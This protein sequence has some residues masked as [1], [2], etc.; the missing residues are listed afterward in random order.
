[1]DPAIIRPGEN[2]LAEDPTYTITL[3]LSQA[4]AICDAVSCIYTASTGEDANSSYRDY[5]SYGFMAEGHEVADRLHELMRPHQQRV[6]AFIR[7]LRDA[8]ERRN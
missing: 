2:P 7:A 5:G 1:M 4:F 8:E 3:T 6:G